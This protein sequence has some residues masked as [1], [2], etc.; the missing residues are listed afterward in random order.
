MLGPLQ[1]SRGVRTLFR[2]VGDVQAFIEMDP[3]QTEKVALELF[4]VQVQ[5]RE[6]C[7][8]FELADNEVEPQGHEVVKLCKNLCTPRRSK[9]VFTLTIRKS[10]NPDINEM[11]YR[12]GWCYC[13][14]S[15]DSLRS[16]MGGPTGMCQAQQRRTCVP[17][18]GAVAFDAGAGETLYGHLTDYHQDGATAT[19]VSFP[20]NICFHSLNVSL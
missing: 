18:V 8:Y 10:R 17:G 1:S 7:W 16:F 19:A 12:E 5:E 13:F 9:F 4:V 15:V 20:S 14:E 6:P 11:D 2:H 3:T